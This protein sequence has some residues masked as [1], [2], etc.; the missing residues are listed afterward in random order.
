M[1]SNILREENGKVTT[2]ILT[3]KN[4]KNIFLRP[5]IG[6]LVFIL[7]DFHIPKSSQ[8]PIVVD[9]F[10]KIKAKFQ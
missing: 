6:G 3:T 8:L 10:D 7:T 4:L 1:P 2:K 5:R 9:K